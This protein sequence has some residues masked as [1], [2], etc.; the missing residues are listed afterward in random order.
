M[1]ITPNVA[2]P[3]GIIHAPRGPS[4]ATIMLTTLENASRE[5]VPISAQI[6][7]GG[8]INVTRMPSVA[9]CCFPMESW[10]LRMS[11]DIMMHVTTNS[12]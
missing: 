3:N 6:N 9:Q 10:R 11:E 5:S 8:A 4:I 1:P 7:T 2:N 12:I